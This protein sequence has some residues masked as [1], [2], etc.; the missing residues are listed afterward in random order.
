MNLTHQLA[1]QVLKTSTRPLSEPVEKMARASLLNVLGTAIG[2]APDRAVNAVVQVGRDHGGHA[3]IP[4]PGRADHLDLLRAATAIGLAAHLDDYDDTH[5]ATVIH[6]GAAALAAAWTTGVFSGAS[7]GQFL[8]AFAIGCEVQLRVGLAMSPW[9]YDQGWHI[10]GTCSPLGAAATAALLNVGGGSAMQDAIGL[11]A[12]MTLGQREG[13]GSMIKPFHPG[14][15]AANGVLAAALAAGGLRATGDPL[16]DPGGFYE[17]LSPRYEPEQLL[18]DWGTR[19]ELLD[20]TFKPY[21]CGIVCH[22]AMDAAIALSDE[23]RDRLDEVARIVILCHP[24]VAELTGNPEPRTGLQ[25][26][27]STIH[28][29][30]AGL[31]DGR[32]GL[33]QYGDGRVTEPDLVSLR[34]R[35]RLQVDPGRSRASAA[36]QVHLYDGT[37]LSQD[38]GHAWGSLERPLTGKELQE[39]VTD[40]IE[41]VLP[42]RSEAIIQCVLHQPL[43]EDL[44]HLCGLLHPGPGAPQPMTSNAVAS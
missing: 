22:P 29:V 39:K 33:P 20:N 40:L 28:G 18:A 43:A 15:G 32:A 13:F 27:F 21:P 9:H 38:V 1:D 24:L 6:P 23:L 11:A 34:S 35:T 8:T 14:K 25:A 10:T 19:W 7:L 17:V 37:V 5:L 41:P 12:D 44:R 26:R 2:A 42:G 36:V 30:A 3:T 31:A 4:I 16:G